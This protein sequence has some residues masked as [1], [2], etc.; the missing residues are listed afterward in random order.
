MK[1]SPPWQFVL[2]D[3]KQVGKGPGWMKNLMTYTRGSLALAA[4][5]K[6]TWGSIRRACS[7]AVMGEPIWIQLG[8]VVPTQRISQ[9]S[10]GQG[11][12]QR[13]WG[14][15]VRGSS[16]SQASSSPECRVHRDLKCM[17]VVTNTCMGLCDSP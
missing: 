11:L 4:V 15:H 12:D 7:E 16:L 5:G 17:H 8:R 2:L 10:Q 13:A 1:E 6:V 3:S 9:A 14:E